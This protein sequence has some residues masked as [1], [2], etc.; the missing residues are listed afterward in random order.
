MHRIWTE[1]QLRHLLPRWSWAITVTLNLDFLLKWGCGVSWSQFPECGN[2][3]KSLPLENGT[4]KSR[5]NTKRR[6]MPEAPRLA[7][8]GCG[9]RNCAMTPVEAWHRQNRKRASVDGASHPQ[10]THDFTPR[11]KPLWRNDLVPAPAAAEPGARPSELSGHQ[12][13]PPGC[14][15]HPQ[16]RPSRGEAQVTGPSGSQAPWEPALNINLTLQL[17]LGFWDQSTRWV[18][19]FWGRGGGT[20]SSSDSPRGL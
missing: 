7:G 10:G 8:L 15:P 16:G 12:P 19:A 2:K 11:V 20:S 14:A 3:G 17:Q 13:G 4:F 9:F 1:A 18:H 6:E 5:H